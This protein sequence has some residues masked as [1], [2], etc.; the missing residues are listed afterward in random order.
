M[1]EEIFLPEVLQC[2]S[3]PNGWTPEEAVLNIKKLTVV[4]KPKVADIINEFWIAHEV[5]VNKRGRKFKEW[6]WERFCKEAGYAE[7]TPV[8]WFQ[9]YELPYTDKG[10][11]LP[12]LQDANASSITFNDREKITRF[13]M[14]DAV[15]TIKTEKVSDDDLK[16]IVDAIA[17]KVAK[18]EVEVRVG[19]KMAR[20]VKQSFSDGVIK[21][22]KPLDNFDRLKKHALALAEGLNY[23]ADGTIKPE[24]RDE[25]MAARIIM[26]AGP[27]II[28]HYSRLGLDIIKIWDM[29]INPDRR[30]SINS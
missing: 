7:T 27:S 3:I 8:R 4:V 2:P 1:N 6:T 13:K 29:F 17:D 18:K 15:Q 28:V 22:P 9:K 14:R 10:R 16:T 24:S 19:T 20:A 26:D 12:K 30:E 21:E 5:I 25:G 23:W 11:T